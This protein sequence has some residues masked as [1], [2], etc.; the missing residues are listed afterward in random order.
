[1][2][3]DISKLNAPVDLSSGEWIDEIP[4]HPGLRLKVRSA[5]FKPYRVAL[6]AFYRA[7]NK[8]IQTDEGFVDAAADAG[9]IAAKHLLIDWD[10]SKAKGVNALTDG[11][12]PVEYSPELALAILT[13][14]D[15]HGIGDEY[16]G[17]VAYAAGKVAE[18]LLAKTESASGN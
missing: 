16:R 9:G 3:F 18:R 15:G 12:K 8:T 7:N 5:R 6:S 17:A 1:M 10:M 2:S 4:D 11:G 13:A 14:D